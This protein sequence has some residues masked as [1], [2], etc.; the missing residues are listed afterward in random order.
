MYPTQQNGDVDPMLFKCW[1]SVVDGGPALKQHWFTASFLL[2]TD[3]SN[4]L[5][6]PTSD[7]A[8][9]RAIT[10]PMSFFAV[11]LVRNS[12]LIDLFVCVCSLSGVVV[13][14]ACLE[15]RRSRVRPRLWQVLKKQKN[16]SPLTRKESVLW[17]AS[18]TER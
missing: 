2:G 15:S 8:R 7:G 5:C 4:S 9:N 10:G 1:P 18:V 6:P 14:A 13:K 16:S 3:A 11:M 12:L 17:G